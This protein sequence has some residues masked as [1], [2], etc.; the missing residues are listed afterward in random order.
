MA[1]HAVVR[2]MHFQAES[3]H[4]CTPGAREKN[5]ININ[6]HCTERCWNKKY[7]LPLAMPSLV[8]PSTINCILSESGVIN[9][10]TD[11]TGILHAVMS[12]G[13]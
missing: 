8:S 13:H 6:I 1:Q 4:R 7:L 2:D 12:N 9:R 11:V 3:H 10:I 5:Y